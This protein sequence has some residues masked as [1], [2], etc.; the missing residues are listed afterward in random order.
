MCKTGYC[1][2][3]AVLLQNNPMSKTAQLP[4]RHS[5]KRKTV[6]LTLWVKPELK[7][8]IQHL[9]ARDQL[10]A[11]RTGGA[12]LEEAVRQQLHIQHAVLLQPI[13]ETTLQ[14]EMRSFQ[15]RLALLLVRC[16]FASEQTRILVANL[17]GRQLG[18]TQPLLEELLDGANGMAKRNMTR[19]TPQLET[20][21]GEIK[22]WLQED[23][24][25]TE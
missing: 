23:E 6:H 2:L 20:L 7:A 3:L 22:Q 5:R 18:V 21:L 13:I 15:N 16:V 1:Q 24:K 12:L 14:R 25:S 10:S 8:E 4:R 11:S 9:A 17:L 19:K